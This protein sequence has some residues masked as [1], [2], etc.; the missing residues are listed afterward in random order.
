MPLSMLAL[1]KVQTAYDDFVIEHAK[2]IENDEAFEDE[3]GWT[4]ECQET[5][6]A[7]H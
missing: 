6:T 3:Q 7:D 2:L 4:G 5:F 1:D